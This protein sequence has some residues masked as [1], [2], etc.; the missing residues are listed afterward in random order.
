M[1]TGISE[2]GVEDIPD[3]AEEERSGPPHGTE[4]GDILR[5]MTSERLCRDVRSRGSCIAIYLT[6][7]QVRKASSG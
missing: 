1:I 2:G 5:G 7:R 4:A 3:E 6:N